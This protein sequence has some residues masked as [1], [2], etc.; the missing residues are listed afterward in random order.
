MQNIWVRFWAVDLAIEPAPF[1]LVN[2]IDPILDLHDDAAVL[3]NHAR[4]VGDAVKALG[5][6]QGDGA[7]GTLISIWTMGDGDV[8]D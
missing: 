4:A 5:G 1:R 7:C 6:F 3:L 2:G 8:G